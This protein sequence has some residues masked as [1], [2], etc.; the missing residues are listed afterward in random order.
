MCR[1]STHSS[2]VEHTMFIE[3][4]NMDGMRSH[5]NIR[6]MKST[7][8]IVLAKDAAIERQWEVKSGDEEVRKKGCV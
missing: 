2:N 4:D 6:Y 8:L 3:A 5:N 1:S 7:Y